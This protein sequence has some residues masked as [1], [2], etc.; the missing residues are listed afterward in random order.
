MELLEELSTTRIWSAYFFWNELVSP[1]LVNPFMIVLRVWRTNIS[2]LILVGSFTFF[3]PRLTQESYTLKLY[4]PCALAKLSFTYFS[5]EL[6]GWGFIPPSFSN[7]ECQSLRC[8]SWELTTRECCAYRGPLSI[9]APDIHFRSEVFSG[10]SIPFERYYVH[11]GW[12]VIVH[13]WV[14]YV[15]STLFYIAGL[16]FTISHLTLDVVFRSCRYF[17]QGYRLPLCEGFV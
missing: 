11:H 14:V 6:L 12:H 16:P 5:Y 7:C 17:S 13:L 8:M 10:L 9:Y 4:S 2:S 3:D 15:W 1:P